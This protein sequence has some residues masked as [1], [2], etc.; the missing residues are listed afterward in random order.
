MHPVSQG[1]ATDEF[2]GVLDAVDDLL[3]GDQNGDLEMGGGIKCPSQTSSLLPL[4]RQKTDQTRVDEGQIKLKE[5][6]LS[7]QVVKQSPTEPGQE[8]MVW[9][10]LMEEAE[11]KE[12]KEDPL[13]IGMGSQIKTAT[14]HGGG[15]QAEDISR[16]TPWISPKNGWKTLEKEFWSREKL[17]DKPLETEVAPTTGITGGL[18]ASVHQSSNVWTSDKRPL[19]SRLEVL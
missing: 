12:K 4:E 17:G 8:T 14:S 10:V 19:V 2:L 16:A 7:L 15:N 5:T 6:S 18:S 3:E 13:G 11:E 1:P 9:Q